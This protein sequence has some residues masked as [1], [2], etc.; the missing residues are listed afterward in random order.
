MANFALTASFRELT[1]VYLVFITPTNFITAAPTYSA[2]QTVRPQAKLNLFQDDYSKHSVMHIAIVQCTFAVSTA[3]FRS[4]DILAPFVGG[5]QKKGPRTNR[6]TCPRV[7][8]GLSL[9][10]LQ[11][12]SPFD[13]TRKLPRAKSFKEIH[14]KG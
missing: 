5:P 8:G 2:L 4:R 9:S 10:H 7:C 6:K 11:K 12:K 13:L 14:L 1:I 3:N